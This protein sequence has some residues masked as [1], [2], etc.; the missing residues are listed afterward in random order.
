MKISRVTVKFPSLK[1][2]LESKT[3]TISN[4]SKIA[5]IM[6][7]ENEREWLE[8]AQTLSSRALQKEIVKS[9]PKSGLS[10]S[11]LFGRIS[12]NFIG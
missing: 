7:P 5:P 10:E 6:R 11:P 12:P 3:I 1:K 9:H 2:A 4:A 8:K